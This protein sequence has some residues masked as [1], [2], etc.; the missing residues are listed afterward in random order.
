MTLSLNETSAGPVVWT[1]GTWVWSPE[2]SDLVYCPILIQVPET[3]QTWSC[4]N[5]REQNQPERK[6]CWYC[7][8]RRAL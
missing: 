1:G 2:I 6:S 4:R 5:C 3:R 7:K 8:T